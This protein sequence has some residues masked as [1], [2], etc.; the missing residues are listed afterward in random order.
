MLSIKAILLI[1]ACLTI[2]VLAI[3]AWHYHSKAKQHVLGLDKANLA[4]RELAEKNLAARNT[5]IISDIKFIA[6]ALKQEQC[7]L[8]EAVLR[9]HHLSDALDTD[10]MLKT[11][12]KNLHAFF[13]K[14]RDMPIKE[15][16]KALSKKERFALDQQRYFLE[17][18]YSKDILA[19]IEIILAGAFDNL[20]DSLQSNFENN[21]TEVR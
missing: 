19:D 21:F 9:I 17:A 8:T 7:E 14:I 13:L 10:I 1:L 11:E 4:E 16:Y 5:N 15:A 2:A 18:Q 3:I 6:N 12:F 20:K